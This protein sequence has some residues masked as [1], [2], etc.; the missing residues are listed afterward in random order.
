MVDCEFN[1]FVDLSRAINLDDPC[2]AGFRDHYVSIFKCLKSVYFDAMAF[3]AIFLGRVVRPDDLLGL[4][5]NLRDAAHA[6]LHQNVAVLQYLDVMNTTPRHFPT[7]AALGLELSYTPALAQLVCLEERCGKKALQFRIQ[8]AQIGRRFAQRS[9]DAEIG[10]ET[11]DK[12]QAY[13]AKA[14]NY[15]VH[16]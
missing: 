16:I 13:L 2:G 12:F 11:S 8:S 1:F 15:L 5:I 4:A 14:F 3:V 6:L 9:V 7:D 10:S